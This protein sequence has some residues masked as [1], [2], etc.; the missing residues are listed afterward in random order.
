MQHLP[1]EK[2]NGGRI[3]RGRPHRVSAGPEATP[4]IEDLAG[5][6]ALRVRP[7]ATA[8]DQEAAIRETREARIPPLLVHQGEVR[9]PRIGGI[10]GLGR[11]HSI[12]EI[13]R[14]LAADEDELA[15]MEYGR[16]VTTLLGR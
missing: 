13:V 9:P 15:V 7:L 2:K 4:R 1:C 6:R 8:H 12:A 10:V 16:D 14:I 11:A 3:F 5:G